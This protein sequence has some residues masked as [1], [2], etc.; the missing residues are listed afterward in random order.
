MIHFAKA[1]PSHIEVIF[2]WLQEPHIQKFWDNSQAH[3]EDILNFIV[4][5]KVPSDYFDGVFEYWIGFMVQDPFAFLMTSYYED[6]DRDSLSLHGKTLT[7]D[8]AIGN[9][10]YLN[11]GLASKTLQ[12]FMEFYRSSV[13]S[14]VTTFFIDPDINN[15]KARHVYEKAGFRTKGTYAIKEGYFTGHTNLIM[16][17]NINNTLPNFR[18]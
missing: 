15:S 11:R 5:R 14:A 9:V 6:W 7:L 2:G 18:S 16:V 13:D 10:A 4:G 12:A 1:N 17:K 3:K 8:F